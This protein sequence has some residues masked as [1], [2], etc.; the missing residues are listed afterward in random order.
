MI[1]QV[2]AWEVGF[3]LLKRRDA[4][5]NLLHICSGRT[6]R[7]K[8]KCLV[9]CLQSGQTRGS[10][11]YDR[12]H[13]ACEVWTVGPRNHIWMR[14]FY[15]TWCYHD[16]WMRKHN[17]IRSNLQHTKSRGGWRLWHQMQNRCQEHVLQI[18]AASIRSSRL[19]S[20]TNYSHY[21]CCQLATK[22]TL[23]SS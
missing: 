21:G 15:P 5:P 13:P 4:C 18:G 17:A 1:H 20:S 16:P 19:P 6:K 9:E 11:Q 2:V 7:T 3:S 12:L 23:P 14:I 22:D 10:S 8:S